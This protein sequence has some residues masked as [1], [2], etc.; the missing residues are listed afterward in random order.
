MDQWDQRDPEEKEEE[1]ALLGRLVFG[2]LMVYLEHLAYQEQLASLV[3]PGSLEPPD[4]KEIWE[5]ED[6]RVALA[7]KAHEVH[8]DKNIL[9]FFFAFI[10]VA[11]FIQVTQENLAGVD[12]LVR[13][14]LLERTV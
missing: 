5:Q 8:W 10:N 6:P 12:H 7:F 4:Q 3:H 1:R 2:E 13:W 14:D 9:F 11:R